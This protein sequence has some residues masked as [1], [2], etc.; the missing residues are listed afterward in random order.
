MRTVL[1]GRCR[2]FRAAN[3]CNQIVD[4][5][6]LLVISNEIVWPVARQK[7]AVIA[8]IVV[9]FG[10][11]VRWRAGA[12]HRSEDRRRLAP[13]R[14]H[15]CLADE[16]S[17]AIGVEHVHQHLDASLSSANEVEKGALPLLHSR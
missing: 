16:L 9:K 1:P 7:D 14:F 5:H 12:S 2:R 8:A 13:S 11:K 17:G 4:D 3:D 15:Q 10:K 6:E